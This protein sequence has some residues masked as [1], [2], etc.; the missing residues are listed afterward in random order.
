MCLLTFDVHDRKIVCVCIFTSGK[1]NFASSIIFTLTIKISQM[2]LNMKI[3]KE[4]FLINILY[5]PIF[6]L[7]FTNFSF[8]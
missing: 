5:A 4:N 1:F 2:P 6:H 8:I 3:A 7:S